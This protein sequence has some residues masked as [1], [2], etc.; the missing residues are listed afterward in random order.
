MRSVFDE[1]LEEMNQELTKLG[2]MCEYA[3]RKAC[4]SL[5]QHDLM[6]AKEVPDL[7]EQINEEDRKI[8]NLCLR[9]LLRQQPV[10]KDLRR[11][12]SAL[13]MITDMRRIGV[14]AA[15][16][17]EIVTMDTIR[18]VDDNVGMHEMAENVMGMVSK[19]MDAFVH[20]DANLARRVIASDDK[21]DLCFDHVREALIREIQNMNEKVDPSQHKAYGTSILDLLMIAKYLERIGDHA[22]R[23]AGWVTFAITGTREDKKESDE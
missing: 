1:Q 11:I 19:S 18:Q 6:M 17:A 10:A 23:I 14:Q 15:D 12:S 7:V 9:L 3:I 16:I 5:L 2:M 13:K 21:V 8:E 20:Q 4:V 22:V